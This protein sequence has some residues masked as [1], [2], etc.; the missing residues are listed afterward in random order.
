[1]LINEDSHASGNGKIK[2]NSMQ[3]N[4]PAIMTFIKNMARQMA[5][6]IM[7]GLLCLANVG[8]TGGG[9]EATKNTERTKNN[10]RTDDDSSGS[11][12]SSSSSS[13][14]SSSSSSSMKS[15]TGIRDIELANIL[16]MLGYI[17]DGCTDDQAV[18]LRPTA[19]NVNS[20]SEK[21]SN[22]SLLSKV[23]HA[24]SVKNVAASIALATQTAPYAELAKN[25]VRVSCLTTDLSGNVSN[26]EI[27]TGTLV[28]LGVPGLEGRVVLTCTHCLG[29]VGE[30]KRSNTKGCFIITRDFGNKGK[31]E[32]V[33]YLSV[34]VA[35][36]DDTIINIVNKHTAAQYYIERYYNFGEVAVAILNK[37]INEIVGL[38]VPFYYSCCNTWRATERRGRRIPNG[39]HDFVIGY[40]LCGIDGS[41]KP[42]AIRDERFDKIL[43]FIDQPNNNQQDV[44]TILYLVQLADKLGWNKKKVMNVLSRG[45]AARI[46]G[47]FSGSLVMELPEN[48]N[49]ITKLKWIGLYSGDSA[50]HV[51]TVLTYVALLEASKANMNNANWKLSDNIIMNCLALFAGNSTLITKEVLSTYCIQRAK[52]LMEQNKKKYWFQLV[53]F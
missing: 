26:V 37:P 51:V 11:G 50:A 17:S 16:A 38:A 14:S 44:K 24:D 49:D 40:G 34:S 15:E 13:N 18:I 46:G 3:L 30:A 1:M 39:M 10:N 28:D 20:G 19:A 23:L 8:A 6:A 7:C 31:K 48:E 53:N 42:L 22:S 2:E 43:T 21:D 25:V 9:G 52:Q 12:S 5:V 32:E 4:I 36:A 33:T 35:N 27:G 47:G 41:I 29:S 45:N